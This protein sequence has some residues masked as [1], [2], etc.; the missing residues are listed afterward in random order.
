M[1][2]IRRDVHH[3]VRVVLCLDD[4]FDCVHVLGQEENAGRISCFL[5]VDE[6]DPGQRKP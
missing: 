1:E 4:H 3:I 5:F 2:D 6:G